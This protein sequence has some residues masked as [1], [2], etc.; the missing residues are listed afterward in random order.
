MKDIALINHGIWI[1]KELDTI[2]QTYRLVEA[3]KS[4]IFYLSLEEI[5]EICQIVADLL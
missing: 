4:R 2:K 5:P 3:I 1:T